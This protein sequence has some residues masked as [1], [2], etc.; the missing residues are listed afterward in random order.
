MQRVDL[1]VFAQLCAL[2][3][4]SECICVFQSLGVLEVFA[5]EGGVGHLRT[6]LIFPKV[7][8][9]PVLEEKEMTPV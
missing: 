3:A 8:T 9:L 6:Q 7:I 2:F 4:I 1:D 5:N